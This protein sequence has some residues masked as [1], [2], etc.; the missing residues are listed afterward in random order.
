[1]TEE[2][3]DTYGVIEVPET[4]PPNL[5]VGYNMTGIP[6]AEK[7]GSVRE[8]NYFY[9]SLASIISVGVISVAILVF[10]YYKRRKN[11]TYSVTVDTELT[12][13]YS[14]VESA[15]LNEKPKLTP[16]KDVPSI[17]IESVDDEGNVQVELYPLSQDDDR[18]KT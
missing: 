6:A 11:N 12:A 5:D 15:P 3:L 7:T 13:D 18:W 9:I 17:Q 14:T 16:L 4:Q 2:G 8:A 10:L 1:M